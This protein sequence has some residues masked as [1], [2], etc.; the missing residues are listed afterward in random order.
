M[1]RINNMSCSIKVNSNAIELTVHSS[2]YCVLDLLYV[3]EDSKVFMD[4][5]DQS[6]KANFGINYIKSGL[7]KLNFTL[8][9]INFDVIYAIKVL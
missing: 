8:N 7:S 1:Y 6:F 5:W 2:C 9:Y 3:T 4:P